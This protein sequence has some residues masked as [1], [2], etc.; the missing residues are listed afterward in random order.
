MR[1]A[2]GFHN[3]EM[4]TVLD[5]DPCPASTESNA[6]GIDKWP[7]TNCHLY[8]ILFFAT[9][10]SAH[11]TARAHEG[12]ST[13]GSLGHGA[14]AWAALS[15]RFDGNTEEARRA[16]R[17]I[18]L[19]TVM[20]PEEGLADF[21]A[22]IDDTRLRLKYMGETFPDESYDDLLVRALT[23]D[24]ELI[25]QTSHRDITFG[26]AE[27]RTTVT[28]TYI[29]GFSRTSSTPSVSG[30]GVAMPAGFAGVQCH[31]WH[32]YG[33]YQKNFPQR[34]KQKKQQRPSN[35]VKGKNA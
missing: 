5:G 8:S 26:L 21:F 13:A 10:G 14:A 17:E 35:R 9:K 15:A 6:D 11:I 33:H 22:K 24:Y 1:Q 34:Q 32:E 2:I 4:Q 12:T 16:C 3:H 27:I 28:N 19:N 31:T 23:K 25:R 18:L 7:K 20:K 30:R 29:D